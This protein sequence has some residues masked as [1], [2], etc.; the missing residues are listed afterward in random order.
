VKSKAGFTALL[1][2]P[3]SG[4]LTVT[5]EDPHKTYT[6]WPSHVPYDSVRLLASALLSVLE[7]R[8][9]VVP[10]NDEPTEHEFLFSVSQDRVDLTVV[11]LRRLQHGEV[12]REPVFNVS[13]TARDVVWPLWRAL[14]EV[15]SKVTPDEYLRQWR[16]PFPQ[17]E[18]AELDR[19]LRTPRNQHP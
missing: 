10:W 4:W 16:E 7:R 13:G 17:A 19:R 14:R 15:E 8:D 2:G 9:A 11:V 6:F 12:V 1:E 3:E 18:V 5:L